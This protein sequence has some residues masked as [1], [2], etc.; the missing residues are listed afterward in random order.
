MNTIV[1]HTLLLPP[2]RRDEVVLGQAER[3]LNKAL[4]PIESWM[5]G[6]DYL[7]GDFSAADIMLG[8]SI[9]MSGRMG[10]VTDEMPNLKAY[11]ER[12]ESRPAFKTAITMA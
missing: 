3:L 11:I 4:K 5:D 6:K 12:I 7:I 9:F 8:H 1:V 2:D 10:C